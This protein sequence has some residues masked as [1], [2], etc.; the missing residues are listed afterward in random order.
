MDLSVVIPT[1]NEEKNIEKIIPSI[2]EEIFPAVNGA[3]I[4]VVDGGSKDRTREVAES[5]NAKVVL[6]DERGYGGA[7]IA[8]FAAA[9]G[10]YILTMDAD[11]SHR[12]TFFHDMFEKMQDS[13]VVVASRYVHGGSA[14]MPVFRKFLSIVLNQFFKRGLSLPI[15]D[16]SSGF[17]LYK[18]SALRDMRILSRDFDVL[19]EILIKLYT[20]GYHIAEVPFQYEPRIEGQTHAKLIQFGIAYLKTFIRMWELRNST[21]AADHEERAYN[22]TVLLQRWWQRRRCS[23]VADLT[24]DCQRTLDIGCGSS[25]ILSSLPN[26]VGVDI[27]LNKLLYARK[28]GKRLV[29]ATALNLP[30]K[31]S[32]FDCV[33]CSKVIEYLDDDQQPF[34]EMTRVLKADGIL[35]VGTPDYSRSTWIALEKIYRFI[36]PKK[37]A[38]RYRTHYTRKK[39]AKRMISLGYE[40]LDVKYIFRSEM[41]FQLRKKNQ[42]M[43][44]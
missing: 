28:Y 5:L 37:Y 40:I 12:P 39:L 18:T 30:F 32:S 15:R 24:K 3:E 44:G 10:K 1:L 2:R 14:T 43:V 26:P 6:Q 8:G 42:R 38:A 7:L 33:V 34:D 13:D 19:E 31:D 22:S 16:V 23:I 21:S 29:N 27:M 9:K 25:R 4:I 11:L 17:R 36:F 35:I 41:I 20:G